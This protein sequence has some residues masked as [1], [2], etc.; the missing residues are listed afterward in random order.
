M[1]VDDNDFR[2]W[3]QDDCRYN[4]VEAFDAKNYPDATL[5]YLKDMGCL[6]IALAI[7]LR[8]FGIEKESDY[9]KFNPYIFLNARNQRVASTKTAI[10]S[11]LIFPGC[12]HGSNLNVFR[13]QEK[14]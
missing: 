12:I 9:N 3:T 4:L 5:R 10:L 8:R 2:T 6:I 11:F 7:M 1:V 14:P 13:I